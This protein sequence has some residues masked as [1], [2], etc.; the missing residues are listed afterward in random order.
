[1][2]FWVHFLVRW[3]GCL[4]FTCVVFGVVYVPETIINNNLHVR[5]IVQHIF[6]FRIC[7]LHHWLVL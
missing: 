7:L 2:Q 4:I 1:M 6:L 5:K 3:Y